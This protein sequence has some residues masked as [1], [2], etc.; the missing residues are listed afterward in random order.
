[1]TEFGDS[2][3]AADQGGTSQALHLQSAQ[4]ADLNGLPIGAAAHS[5]GVFAKCASTP[6]G[7][8]AGKKERV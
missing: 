8:R 5:L 1:L 3:K 6:P 2:G 4:L 7:H